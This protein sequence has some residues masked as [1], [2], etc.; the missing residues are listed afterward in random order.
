[1]LKYTITEND[2]GARYLT[3]SYKDK[4]PASFMVGDFYKKDVD[5]DAMY[6]HVNQYLAT[7]PDSVQDYLFTTIVEFLLQIKENGERSYVTRLQDKIHN[8]INTLDYNNF[9]AWFQVNGR[10]INVPDTVE[11]SF[12]Q[13]Q[14]MNNTREKT[15]VLTEYLSLVGFVTF[16][17]LLSPLLVDYYN[18]SK[19]TRNKH[20]YRTFTLLVKND[21]YDGE[22]LDKLRDYL[23]VNKVAAGTKI[24]ELIYDG[25]LSSDD[26]LDDII[27]EIIF[28]KL[29]SIDF[30]KATSNV[31]AYAYKT[32]TNIGNRYSPNQIKSKSGKKDGGSE[33]PSYFEDYR[34]TSDISVGKITAIQYALTNQDAILA[35]V[36]VTRFNRT[37][38]G[39]E[40]RRAREYVAKSSLGSYLH[41]S[42]ITI[43]SWC[44]TKYINPRALSHVGYAELIDL[45]CMF[46][47]IAISKGYE[48]VG[49]FLNSYIDNDTEYLNNPTSDSIRKDESEMLLS[50]FSNIVEFNKALRVE[51]TVL[52]TSR[53]INSTMHVA[54]NTIPNLEEYITQENVL[55]PTEHL[56]KDLVRFIM[57]FI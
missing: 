19:Q 30:V 9:D 7:L 2:Y 5:G 13:D 41:K 35:A 27:S 28:N 12:E 15:Y 3:I 55:I 54:I 16:M 42:K 40:V 31:V 33:Q 18:Y 45:L 37:I 57:E 32:L 25:G 1:M 53:L 14:D 23:S 6:H 43:L 10:D 38:H 24:E 29:L 50:R 48:Y 4:K 51:Q 52:E 34:K 44:L 56:N 39:Q 11:E 26:E 49:L 22:V 17:R 46:K 21:I 8:F 36:G 47:I 20:L